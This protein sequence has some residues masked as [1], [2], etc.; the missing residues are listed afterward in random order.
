MK[1]PVLSELSILALVK[2]VRYC[3]VVIAVSFPQGALMLEGGRFVMVRL[4]FDVD[5]LAD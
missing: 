3:W 2:H 4:G 1:A 5:W